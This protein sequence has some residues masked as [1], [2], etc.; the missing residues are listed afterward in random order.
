MEALWTAVKVIA[1]GIADAVGTMMGTLAEKLGNADFSG[2]LDV[3]NSI[4]VGGIALSISKFLKSVTEPLEGL[5]DILEGVTEFLMVSEDAL[6]HI[7][8]I[9]KPERYLKS[10]QQSLCLLVLS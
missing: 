9:L 2:V 8:Q 7:G 6:R 1:G 10:K 4:A 3:L 5:S